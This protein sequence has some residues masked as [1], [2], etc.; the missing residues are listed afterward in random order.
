MAVERGSQWRGWDVHVHTPLSFES[1]FG[2]S[3]DERAEIDT[4]PELDSFDTP[5]RF[6]SEIWAKYV[7]ELEAIEKIDCIGITDY[8]SIEGYELIR[9]LRNHGRLDNFD[10]V[11]PNIEFRLDTFT[12]EDNPINLHVIFSEDL[13]IDDIRNEFLEQLQISLGHGNNISLRPRNLKKLGSQAKERYSEA[14]GLSDYKAG[15][16][17]ARVKLDGILNE[18]ESTSLFEGKYLIVLSASEWHEINWH[19][20]HAEKKRQLLEC[21]HALFSGSEDD[22]LWITGQGDLSPDELKDFF[23][24]KIP[25]LHSSDSH[26]FER[27][28]RPDEDKYCWIK[29]DPTFEGLK[30]VIFEPI[31][32]I[33]IGSRPEDSYVQIQT[34]DSLSIRDGEVNDDLV[35]EDADIPFNSNL[36]S[37]IGSQGAGKTALLDLIAHSFEDRGSDTT[38]DD[39]SFIARIESDSPDLTTTLEFTGDIDPISKQVTEPET[40]EGPDISHLP[41]G[42]IVEYCEKGNK[43][44]ERIRDLVTESV[45]TDAS[46]LVNDLEEKK[47]QISNI[48]GKLRGANADLH[49][50]NP[51]ETNARLNEETDNLAT[52]ETLLKNKEEEIDQFKEEHE[53]ELEETEAEELQNQQDELIAE[54]GKID[55]F[56]SDIESALKQLSAI[57]EFNHLI[58]D[59]QNSSELIDAEIE[60]DE[61][62]LTGQQESLSELKEDAIER[63]ES[64]QEE[65]GKIR[66]NLEELGEA[67]DRLSELLDEKRRISDRVSNANDRIQEFES[68]LSRANDIRQE[69]EEYFVDYVEAH[70]EAR[71]IYED[72]ADR[73]S[74]DETEVLEE[75]KFK[76]SI[77]LSEART[78]DYEDVL[79]MRS[80]NRTTISQKLSELELIVAGE[81]PD[82]LESE[83]T[84]YLH[85]VEE[86]RENLLDSRDPIEFDMIVYDECLQ[87]TEEIYYQDTHMDQLSRGQKGTVLLRVY[88]AKGENP[89]IIDSPEE[90]LDNRYVYEELI[91]AIRD[92]K[93][94]RQIF[95]ASHDANLVVNTDSEQIVIATFDEG[96]MTFEAGALEN[97]SIRN[98]AKEIL[99]G[100]DEAFRQREEKYQLI[101]G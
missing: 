56:V 42:K 20:R 101:P 65:I 16:T 100:G 57:D 32:R 19:G 61:I 64:L 80:L 71:E 67:E 4:I 9:H 50:I 10:V 2:I 30:Q 75:I 13:D 38:D 45:R 69:R 99:E 87:L 46:Q 70:F 86:L 15:C 93:K 79:D 37:I 27:L 40:I 48:A 1:H 62:K 82:N 39:N 74:E 34:I 89:L 60:I 92:A 28:C 12:N 43:I 33:S 94:K 18:L 8:F 55:E 11:V 66:E 31:E 72:I 73:F 78:D 77:E 83:V 68:E 52:Q 29:A 85:N 53:Q 36:V 41:Q 22:H 25:P 3:D 17:Y 51:P 26:D 81:K 21:A 14:H 98:E 97:E 23:G 84:Q 59:I 44:H 88:L 76:P 5:D 47:D 24:G 54:S 95:I 91:D 7:E 6:D 96:S 90:N 58:R 49:E 63:Q 35:I